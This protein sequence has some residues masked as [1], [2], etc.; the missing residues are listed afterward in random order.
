VHSA[1]VLRDQLLQR[2]PEKNFLAPL[3]PKVFGMINLAS[4]AR[5]AGAGW[6]LVFSSIQSFFNNAGQSSYA[7]GSTFIDRYARWFERSSAL[8]V[9]VINWG[10]WGSVGIVASER[11][12]TAL[13][14]RGL[15][16]IEVPQGIEAVER[17]L[18]HQLPEL[19]VLRAS[20]SLLRT[21]QVDFSRRKVTQAASRRPLLAA[22]EQGILGL[23]EGTFDPSAV[24]KEGIGIA[25]LENFGQLALAAEMSEL[26][27]PL[28][29]GFTEWKRDLGVV[30]RHAR[31]FASMLGLLTQAGYLEQAGDTHRATDKLRQLERAGAR[32][33]RDGFHRK[34]VTAYPELQ[35]HAELVLH[36]IKALPEVLRGA[37]SATEVIFPGGS[38]RMVER[39]YRG[40]PVTDYINHLTA[41]AVAQAVA[42]RRAEIPGQLVRILEVGA[43]TGSTTS[44]VA[45]ALQPYADAVDYI[46]SDVS[47]SFKAHFESRFAAA[48]PF[49][50]FA[51]VDLERGLVH[52]EIE[53]GTVDIV[54]AANA[55]HVGASLHRSL[56]LLKGFLRRNGLLVLIEVTKVTAFNTLVYGLLDAWWHFEDGERRLPGAPVLSREQWLQVLSEEGF[57][58]ATALEQGRPAMDTYLTCLAA[59][60]DG[61]FMVETS[62][63]AD[64]P[65]ASGNA[66]KPSGSK[67]AERNVYC[68]K[69]EDLTDWLTAR[70]L[71]ILQDTLRLEES[72]F[73][74]ETTFDRMGVDSIVGVRVIQELNRHLGIDLHSVDLFNYSTVSSLVQRMQTAFGPAVTALFD[75]EQRR[76]PALTGGLETSSPVVSEV[77]P[78]GGP[79]KGEG[80]AG[81]AI[82]VIGVSGQFP[83]AA[84][85]REFWANLASGCDSITEIPASR[86]PF[87]EHYHETPGTPGRT[88]C[89]W[90]GFLAAVDQFDPLF[91]SISPHEAELMDP[92]HRLFLMEAWKALEDAGYANP[93]INGS[94]CGV[95]VG[96][97]SGD[98]EHVLRAAG[99]DEEAYAFMGTASAIL[100][101]RI[102]YWLNL[103]GPS[104]AID[105]ACSSSGVAIHLACDSLRLRTS[106]LALAGGISVLNTPRFHVLAS[107]TGMLSATGKCRTFSAEVD[108]FVPGEAVAVFV[109]KRLAEALR[110]GDHLYGV[111]R[112]SSI[113]Q[114]GRTNGITAPSGPAQTALTSEVY[115]RF[116]I[117]PESIGYVECHG[118]GTRLGDPIEVGAL[119]DAFRRF[120]ARTEF[121]ALGSVKSNIGHT[122][123]AS[124][125]VGMTKVLLALQHGQLPPTLHAES[126]NPELRLTGSPFTINHHLRS[127]VSNGERPRRAAVSSFGFSGTNAHLVIEEAPPL[128]QRV[129]GSKP[130]YLLAVAAHTEAML[131]RRLQ[132]LEAWLLEGARS[133]ALEEISFSLNAGRSHFAKRCALIVGSAD[134]LRETLR[135]LASGRLAPN[136]FVAVVNGT[137]P[138]GHRHAVRDILNQLAA[139]TPGHAE[140]YREHLLR[141]GELYVQ[142]AEIDWQ[143]LHRGESQ[144]RI[145]LP[146]GPFTLERFWAEPKPSRCPTS[147]PVEPGPPLADPV[148]AMPPLSP[149]IASDKD[150][151]FTPAWHPVPLPQ[152][153]A[154]A[155]PANVLVFDESGLMTRTVAGR[156]PSAN[157][158]RVVRGTAFQDGPD[159]VAVRPDCEGDY[160]AVLEKLHPDTILYTWRTVADL[161]SRPTQGMEA[162]ACFLRALIRTRPKS[163]IHFVYG[164]APGAAPE[165]TAINALLATAAGE[166]PKIR[167]RTV[168]SP[169]LEKVL[170]E[171][172]CASDHAREVRYVDGRREVRSFAELHLAPAGEGWFRPEGVYL[173]SGGAGG[174]GRVISDY[175]ARTYRARLVWLNRSELNEIQTGTLA[176]IETQ[177]TPVLQVRGDVG[178]PDD[179]NRA[180]REA[181][182]QFGVIHGVLHAAGVMRNNF[183]LNQRAEDVRTVLT[184]KV[185][186]T[187]NLDA[188]LATD[189]LDCFL[190]FS[191]VASVLPEVGQSDY[192]AANRFLDEFASRRE[193]LRLQ[194]LRSG[195]TMA[196]NWQMWRDGGMV[197]HQSSETLR[198]QAEQT[199]ESTGLPPLSA[200]KGLELLER[201]ARLPMRSGLVCFGDPKR[202][203]PHL[204]VDPTEPAPLVP[205]TQ[206]LAGQEAL[207]A[208]TQ[209]YVEQLLS[210]LFKVPSERF[211]PDRALNDYG[212]DS[213]LVTRFN[214]RLA[215]DLPGASKSLLFEFS[216]A[217]DLARHLLAAHASE[218]TALW[219]EERSAEPAGGEVSA[220]AVPQILPNPAI[221]V[222][223][224]ASSQPGEI[225]IIG[226][227]GRY[228][229]AP[230]LQEFWANLKAG[231]DCIRELPPA[232]WQQTDLFDPDRSK[233]AEGKL[234]CKWGGFMDGVDE[235]DAAFFS[236]SPIDAESIDPQQRLFLQIA[237][238]ALEAAGYAR[239]P[240]LHWL[241]PEHRQNVGVFAGVTHNSYQLMGVLR[242]RLQPTR[243][244]HSGEWSLANRVS[245]FFDFTGPS[246]PVDTA[247]SASL[248]AI[249]LACE[250]LRHGECRLAVAG[251]VNL[252][253]D[254]SKLVNACRLGM[255]SPSGRCRSFGAG[256]DGYVPGEGAG[257]VVLKPL[258]EAEADGDF[259]H[260]VI[261]ASAI[262]HGGRTNGF[263]VPD[264]AAQ[265]QVILR[266][267]E[268]AG[269]DPR[270]IS[271][272]EGHG[273]GTELGDPIEV[274]GLTKAFGEGLHRRGLPPAFFKKP[275]CALGS[276]KANIG[277]LEAAA[278]I[279]GLTKILL[280]MRHQ[281]L[282]PSLHSEEPNPNID[283][284]R[285]PF[286]LQ[287]TLA[288]WQRPAV[289]GIVVPRRAA[290]SS[291][292]AGGSN[293]HL[294]VEEYVPRTVPLATKTNPHLVVL[295]A[296]DEPQLQA[297][298]ANLEKHLETSDARFPANLGRVAYSLQVGREAMN[299]RLAFV[300]ATIPELRERLRVFCA[301]SAGSLVYRGLA[302]DRNASSPASVPVW[303]PGA[304]PRTTDLDSLAARWVS[305]EE[306]DWRRLHGEPAPQKIPLPP[307]PFLQKR[308]WYGSFSGEN[309]M[310]AAAPPEHSH[311][312]ARSTET[313]H[314][315][316]ATGQFGARP[317]VSL[318]VVDQEVAIVRMQDRENRNMFTA[319][320]L[321]GL[322]ASFAEIERNDNLKAV[323][324]TGCDQVFSMGG[325]REELMNLSD[326]VRTFADLEFIFKG[327]L[328]C[329]VP[330]IAAMQGHASGGGLVFGLYADI[331]VMA[332]EALYSAVFTKYGFTPGLGATF[333]LRERLGDA[334]ATEMM[335]TAATYRGADLKERGANVLFK[336]QSQVNAEALCLARALAV[337]PAF[338]LRTL[339]QSLAGRKLARLPEIIQEELRMHAATFGNPEVKKR[340]TQFIREAPNAI[341]SVP[342]IVPIV[343][344]QTEDAAGASPTSSDFV[345]SV[346]AGQTSLGSEVA[347]AA[348]NTVDDPSPTSSA[349][350]DT[351]GSID[352]IHPIS[353]PR[354]RLKSPG[355][356]DIPDVRQYLATRLCEALHLEPGALEPQASFRDL[357]L[358]SVSG[359]EFI[360][361]V[362][363]AF[364]L[365]LD[366]SVVYDYVNFDALCTHITCEVRKT[367]PDPVTRAEASSTRAKKMLS[368]VGS[369]VRAA[370]R[371]EVR[372]EGKSDAAGVARPSPAPI[373]PLAPANAPG[374]VRP[375]NGASAGEIRST[376]LT[377]ETM[378]IAVIGMACRLPGAPDLDAFWR[379]IAGGVDSV[380]EVPPER[381]DI[382]PYFDLD[383]K[384]EGKTY[385]KWG[386]YLCDVDKFDPLFFH[387]SHAEAEVMDPQQRLFLEESWKAFE[388]AG[389]SPKALSNVRCGVFVGAAVGDYGNVLRREN[390][391]LARSAYAGLGLTPSIL[392]ARIS[393]LL[394][395]KGPSISIDTACSSS[396]VAL[397]QACR[398]I[399]AGDCDMAIAGGVNL[400]L[401]VDQ[402][403]TTSR[404]QMFS[405]VGRCRP[406]DHRA[407]GIALSEGVA[408]V[409][410]K[411]LARA[412][413]DGDRIYGV[414]RGSG[415][416][417]DGRTNGITAPSAIS[418]AE[419]ISAVY[420]GARINPEELDLI[421]AHGTGT[422]LGDPVEIRGLTAAF[423]QFTEQTQFCAL[424][425]VKSNIGHTSFTAGLA[426][427]IKVLLALEYREL[428]PSIHFEKANEQIDFEHTPFFVNTG[429]KTWPSS[430]L[431]P[432]RAAVSS[433][434]Y[435]GTNAHVLLEEHLPSEQRGASAHEGVHAVPLSAKT[436]EALRHNARRLADHLGQALVKTPGRNLLLREVA[437]VLQTGR[438]AMDERV[439]F[440]ASSLPELSSKLAAFLAGDDSMPGIYRTAVDGKKSDQTR[441][442]LPAGSVENLARAW[443]EGTEV[444]WR[445]GYGAEMPQRVPLPTYPFARERCWVPAQTGKAAGALDESRLLQHRNTSTTAGLRFTTEVRPGTALIDDHRVGHE[446]LLAGAAMLELAVAAIREATGQTEVELRDVF[447]L[448]PLPVDDPRTVHVVLTIENGEISFEILTENPARVVHANG[449]AR[450][451]EAFAPG[452]VDLENIRK[453]CTREL[454]PLTFYEELGRTGLHYGAA[455]QVISRLLC[456]DREVLGDLRMPSHLALGPDRFALPPTLI[457][458]ALQTVAMLAAQSQNA[459]PFSLGRLRF[460][461]LTV[462]AYAYAVATGTEAK[463]PGYRVILADEQGREM[464]VLDGLVVR[465][466]STPAIT[467]LKPVWREQPLP[468]TAPA[469][470]PG[471]LLLLDNEHDLAARLRAACPTLELVRVST[472]R[473]YNR[474][475]ASITIEPNRPE[476]FQRLISEVNAHCIVHRWARAGL[477]HEAAVQDGFGSIFLLVRALIERGV[478]RQL[479]I[480]FAYPHGNHPAYAAV[481]AFA[482]TLQQ[483]HPKLLLRTLAGNDPDTVA[484]ELIHGDGDLEVSW[485]GRRR[486]VRAFAP[487]TPK[488]VAALPLREGGTY[489]ITGGTG[490]LGRI[491]TEYLAR[492]VRARIV[493]L[494]RSTW[495]KS[496]QAQAQLWEKHG[497]VI[498]NVQG[499]V[500]RREDV[501]GCVRLVKQRHGAL[502]GI[503][504]A[505]G[506]TRDGLLRRKNWTD[507]S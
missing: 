240:A 477:T 474:S 202:L 437:Y 276:V 224:S 219:A 502:H 189:P 94:R 493:L 16:S 422:S 93:A 449:R 349:V 113:N 435:S 144:R 87:H 401:D 385:S 500:T 53:P 361:G 249:H 278:G 122:A 480:L 483:E 423:R 336:P 301:G 425:S 24:Q 458:G 450:T 150:L 462:P 362:N 384:A 374:P 318:E 133:A 28:T 268:K 333:I 171:E 405:P 325:T 394:N 7:A 365:H 63:P 399:Q 279:A 283:F 9:H 420:R 15:G 38:L 431:R 248:S 176:A 253:L 505:A 142:G 50:R 314:W 272:V 56:N 319:A 455:F 282:V 164:L 49:A 307:Y 194:G 289:D 102:S 207:A 231:R 410:V 367:R 39:I 81:D 159:V 472:G 432:R 281:Q 441:L 311:P 254:A 372:T 414:I 221:I 170:V 5:S 153:G 116:D 230:D 222:G 288:D 387:L 273:T 464:V 141:L 376:P 475:D 66:I 195:R 370:E 34:L 507:V 447:W 280:Q 411:P 486:Q 216:N 162:V 130:A 380:T 413:E 71:E 103:K 440:L 91:F 389:Y 193:E 85:L 312:V 310:P 255:L 235:F 220:T 100:A 358:D 145:S 23:T 181:K 114:D 140:R 489:L 64:R 182:K 213:I 418:Q 341:V 270:S 416:N 496:T 488:A 215:K 3:D 258:S 428:P 392:A 106:D 427:V 206:A 353:S 188:A 226:L 11:Y 115:G 491:F 143:N 323:V 203:L 8:P 199:V 351:V 309:A 157:V 126:V 419:L 180:V 299:E 97:G 96:C 234:Y 400:I 238:H 218:L 461:R 415:V 271:Y 30:P 378:A 335:M 366:A 409:V 243:V 167:V 360:H 397:H 284:S 375:Q 13:A 504:H 4:A 187:L 37:K 348:L 417:Q 448:R 104:L 315:S 119:T 42:L 186:G 393:Y 198:A 75:S 229:L 110:D 88:Y 80:E 492:R 125:A 293:A 403:I 192:A 41:A 129:S 155:Q 359:V 302:S 473:E 212:L 225:A 296:R 369:I 59:E 232:R 476:D 265:A 297:L 67:P 267:L 84:N 10:F 120:T 209:A 57:C 343:T 118:T 347:P 48:T 54:L 388:H 83:G 60:S 123:M 459:V 217:T 379:N 398:S 175:L 443:V 501:A 264:P 149:E 78:A 308:Y 451:G 43:G 326:Q 61:R 99:R 481:H 205:G 124:A 45:A 442:A 406:F 263:T 138:A 490:A 131:W 275:W 51:V 346:D 65:A 79:G 147:H 457:D 478:D 354:I 191:S 482:R 390:P 313:S 204:V 6:L 295:S 407:D 317:E 381:L 20:P 487:F 246:L 117:N 90:G 168:I 92:Q 337:K 70:V 208:K 242:N 137:P 190:L 44:F 21:F 236:I 368:P 304:S 300:A 112:G 154:H 237:W 179:V 12:R 331:V 156:I 469:P 338:T 344:M 178:R 342:S 197:A 274:D 17:V 334:L 463:T 158:V 434:G 166:N 456:G 251:G 1:L 327:F 426:G 303:Q 239:S 499:D 261:K 68:D 495:S 151:Y 287:R 29:S 382:A 244:D 329:R 484:E 436:D 453:R 471:T 494:S 444:D 35:P 227:A 174:L 424:G 47:P 402:L 269:I 322:M 183:L 22:L 109:L 31:V 438:D 345:V 364:G 152:R 339:K 259:I 466:P 82:A 101:S 135:S 146:T 470:P 439:A 363:R 383:P 163:G 266:T 498:S 33:I 373:K 2:M 355:A 148:G 352:T 371:K 330:V 214:A 107:Q 201:S 18:A 429:L 497:A 305:G 467:Y 241:Q 86:W 161:G 77:G 320:V 169:D 286:A 14:E 76:M 160:R 247:C 257:A 108:G 185:D 430:G 72:D 260:A 55:V 27:L 69:S 184:A 328:Q 408:V 89:K 506:I 503:F 321:E 306:I 127:W 277:H 452:D 173:I 36:C 445:Q 128:P 62:G 479:P 340:V 32:A 134:E 357:G 111:I 98:Y 291:F 223:R 262:N 26:S 211:E 132:D 250:S 332:E 139:V 256:A 46:Y 396:L 316:L 446:R 165:E 136:A 404:L 210:E 324:V 58:R 95:F 290:L 172:A 460:S 245:Y 433:F 200:E 412:V 292:G 350:I 177:G 285:T 465:A 196:I 294:I 252:H 356:A 74:R 19:T 105:T 454:D 468:A 73:S 228:P 421:E 377:G 391:A 121:C 233:A 52:H 298:A 485:T 25:E 395:L 40:T 386:G